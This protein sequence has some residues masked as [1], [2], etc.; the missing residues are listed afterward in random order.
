MN[1]SISINLTFKWT[2]SFKFSVSEE[3]LIGTLLNHFSGN[4]WKLGKAAV[5]L[6]MY[7]LFGGHNGLKGKS[8]FCEKL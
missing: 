2:L 7:D 5:F 4:E 1:Y 3:V 6:S 8:Y